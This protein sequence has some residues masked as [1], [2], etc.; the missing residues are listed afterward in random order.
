MKRSI[1]DVSVIVVLLVLIV[2]RICVKEEGSPWWI[3]TINFFGL[4]IAWVSLCLQIK[5]SVARGVGVIIFIALLV[6][7]TAIFAGQIEL[8]TKW[9]DLILLGTLLISLPANLY[10]SL[11]QRKQKK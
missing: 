10:S 4:V 5:N 8:S 1:I 11:L 6:I 3:S 7:L 9:N 2:L